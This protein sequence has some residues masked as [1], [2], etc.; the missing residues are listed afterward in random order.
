MFLVVGV[1]MG[2]LP[3]IAKHVV[4]LLE[5]EGLLNVPGGGGSDGLSP[6]HS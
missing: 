3:I 1:V 6:H 2:S 5:T 4:P